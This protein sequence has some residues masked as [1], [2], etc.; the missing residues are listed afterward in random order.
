MLKTLDQSAKW[1]SGILKENN[2]QGE[3]YAVFVRSEDRDTNNDSSILPTQSTD[4]T[5]A[6]ISDTDHLSSI[7]DALRPDAMIGVVGTYKSTP[8]A[9]LGYMFHPAAWGKGYATEAV[10]AFVKMF[11]T[12]KP[13][14]HVMEARVDSRNEASKKVV[15]KCGFVQE[16]YL[17]GEVTVDWLEPKTRDLIVYR[18]RREKEMRDSC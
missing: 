12:L 10:R 16:G 1:L 5:Q 9:E 13:D 4:G 17:E 15:S 14:V 2:P 3:N 7:D 18:I 8:I 11:W 6:Q